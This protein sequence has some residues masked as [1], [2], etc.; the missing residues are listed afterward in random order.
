MTSK[1]FVTPNQVRE[2]EYNKHS[3][4]LSLFID[5]NIIKI[6]ELFSKLIPEIIAEREGNFKSIILHESK[7]FKQA[8]AVMWQTILKRNQIKSYKHICDLS[9]SYQLR[10]H[11]YIHETT[12]N[13]ADVFSFLSAMP[14]NMNRYITIRFIYRPINVLFNS[15]CRSLIAPST[16]IRKLKLNTGFLK[17]EIRRFIKLIQT[18]LT[19]LESVIFANEKGGL[20]PAMFLSTNLNGSITIIWEHASKLSL[21]NDMAAMMYCTGYKIYVHGILKVTP[22]YSSVDLSRY[23]S[24]LSSKLFPLAKRVLTTFYNTLNGHTQI[25]DIYRYLRINKP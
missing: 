25:T 22:S 2:G 23:L 17:N 8:T 21:N 24:K 6:N 3:Q 5:L 16:K 18:K 10:T 4:N 7:L 12:T 20:I 13:I 9:I 19:S 11:V 15:F 14:K 1:N